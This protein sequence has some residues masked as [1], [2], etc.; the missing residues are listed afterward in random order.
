ML[1]S[2]IK[3]LSFVAMVMLISFGAGRLMEAKGAVTI[4]YSG[5][6]LSFGTLQA[7]LTGSRLA[8]KPLAFA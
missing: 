8:D 5:F 1:W 4:Q 7:A 3:I 6:E 2:L